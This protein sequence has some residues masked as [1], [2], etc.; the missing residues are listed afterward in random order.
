MSRYERYDDHDNDRDNDHGQ[1]GYKFSISGSTV[2]AVYEFEDG[3]LKYERMDSDESWAFDGSSVTKT[4]YDDG[5]LEITTYA[6]LDGDGVFTKVGKSYGA[7]TTTTPI[8]RPD[9]DD[10]YGSTLYSGVDADDVYAGSTL[11][12]DV[13]DSVLSNTSALTGTGVDDL[14]VGTALNGVV[15]APTVAVPSYYSAYTPPSISYHFDVLNGEVVTATRAVNGYERDVRLGWNESW[16]LRGNDV[17]QV[18]TKWNE[19]ETT[20]FTDDNFD[21]AFDHALDIE[22]KTQTSAR[23]Y[24]DNRFVLQDGTNADGA[25]L[26]VGDVITSQLEANRWGWQPERLDW[27]EDLSVTEIDG[28]I[29]IMKSETKRSGEL[30]FKLYRDDDVDGLWTEV[31][32]GDAHAAFLDDTGALDAIR[33]EDTGLLADSYGIIA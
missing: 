12:A 13:D 2:N 7:P 32:Q 21:G 4:E 9:A 1:E 24:E 6:D 33:L 25:N 15:T 27:N 20:L 29:Y 3:R 23:D 31:A 28:S 14:T 8:Y 16:E 22:V 19:T 18:Q 17:A 5:R 11:T 10:S 26:F 30:E